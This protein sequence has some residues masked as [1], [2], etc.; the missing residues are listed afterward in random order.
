M[1]NLETLK[2]LQRKR[3][4][5]SELINLGFKD[6]KIVKYDTRQQNILGKIIYHTETYYNGYTLTVESDEYVHVIP[7]KLNNKEAEI[8]NEIRNEELNLESLKFQI[9]TYRVE[10]KDN[11]VA[12]ELEKKLP[13]QEAKIKGLKVK[14]KLINLE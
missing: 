5:I 7:N 6:D 14:L 12:N 2:S 8:H 4:T 10:F 9:Q 11:V 13:L 3:I 1:N